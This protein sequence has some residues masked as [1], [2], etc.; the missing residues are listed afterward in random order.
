MKRAIAEKEPVNTK[1]T[2]PSKMILKGD[3][4]EQL[5]QDFVPVIK[6]MALRLV[7]RVSSGLNVEDL[8]SAGTVGL[9]DAITKFD[10]SREIKFRTYAEFRIRGA[11]LDEIRAMDWVPR[12]MRERIGKIQH[13]AN[14]Y[15]KRKGRPPTEAEL[16]NELGMEPEEVD[17]TLLQA[18]GSVILSLEDLGSNDDDSHPILDALADRDQPNP[19]ES[20]LSEDT[21]KILADAID[22]LPER[23]RLVLTLYYFEEL[24]MKEIGATLN[25][26]ES[27]ICQLHAQAMIRLKSH[28]HNRLS[29]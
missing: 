20:L 15:T 18:K 13:A 24:T 25:V 12:S 26:T 17:E 27:R 29:R 1:P 11:M 10:P 21:R 19:L 8:I 22:H 5:I 2:I 9:L 6:Y 3:E 4:R 16:A 7:M 14:E 23:Q 28:L